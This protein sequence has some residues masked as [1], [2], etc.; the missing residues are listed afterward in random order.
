MAHHHQHRESVTTIGSML[1]DF[2]IDSSILPRSLT[3]PLGGNLRRSL[4]AGS[5][6]APGVHGSEEY[7]Y[8]QQDDLIDAYFYG[9]SQLRVPS[10]APLLSSLFSGH[11]SPLPNQGLDRL[12]F[13]F[14][15][16]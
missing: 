4:S 14:D 9:K 12:A 8:E 15:V 2:S 3:P 16:R 7:W 11:L 13:V 10:P 1:S 6:R 5:R